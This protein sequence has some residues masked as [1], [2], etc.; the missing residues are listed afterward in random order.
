[1]T[2]T[3]WQPSFSYS[4]AADSNPVTNQ[5]SGNSWTGWNTLTGEID[6]HR[7]SGNN[8]L[9]LSYLAGGMIAVGGPGESGLS[10]N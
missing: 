10:K 5:G 6:V 1:M 3:Y 7:V 9:I 4:G 2:R 8:N